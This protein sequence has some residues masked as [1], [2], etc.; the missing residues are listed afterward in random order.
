MPVVI[1]NAVSAGSR[2]MSVAWSVGKLLHPGGL[3][4]I[5][6]HFAEHRRSSDGLKPRRFGQREAMTWEAVWVCRRVWIGC[7]R[8]C[9]FGCWI[10][11]LDMPRMW[12]WQRWWMRRVREERMDFCMGHCMGAFVGSDLV[13]DWVRATW[14]PTWWSRFGR[15]LGESDLVADLVGPIW[16][17]TW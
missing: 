8:H 1:R 9:C 2:S 14:W 16:W 13:A 3:Q 12:Q 10:L 17:P 4:R 11:W 7:W 15:R 6:P 5:N